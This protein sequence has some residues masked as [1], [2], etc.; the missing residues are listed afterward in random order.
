MSPLFFWNILETLLSHLL[1]FCWFILTWHITP[2]TVNQR[3][4]FKA[5]V[6]PKRK[7]LW[8]SPLSMLMESQVNFCSPQTF[9]ELHSKTQLFF[10]YHL[11]ITR[12]L[13]L[14]AHMLLINDLIFGNVHCWHD[15]HVPVFLTDVR[16]FTDNGTLNGNRGKQYEI[17]AST[18]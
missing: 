3:N 9:L 2:P 8:S 11:I 17:T 13:L 16:P 6:C 14:I 5:S 18:V 15:I 7:I 4:S 12:R 1:F 10:D